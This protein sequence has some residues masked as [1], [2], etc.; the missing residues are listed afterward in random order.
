MWFAQADVWQAG[1][2]AG[3]DLDA[4]FISPYVRVILGRENER[5]DTEWFGIDAQGDLNHRRISGHR[6]LVHLVSMDPTFRT[7]LVREFIEGF[8]R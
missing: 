7:D 4:E 3:I 1:A 5:S 6:Y 8:V 2:C